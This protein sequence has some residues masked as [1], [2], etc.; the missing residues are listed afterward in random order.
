MILL[1]I[2]Q[3]LPLFIFSMFQQWFVSLEPLQNKGNHVD[4]RRVQYLCNSHLMQLNMNVV[5]IG[6]CL[7]QSCD[8]TARKHCN[9][10]SKLSLDVVK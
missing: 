4:P 7:V 9:P 8:D 1:V 10:I 3:I 2:Y 5:Y 6:F